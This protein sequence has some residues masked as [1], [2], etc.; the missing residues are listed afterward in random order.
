MCTLYVYVCVNVGVRLVAFLLLM[1]NINQNLVLK[2][3]PLGSL[4]FASNE[5]SARGQRAARPDPC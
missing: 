4:G 1:T 5:S 2:K 3:I